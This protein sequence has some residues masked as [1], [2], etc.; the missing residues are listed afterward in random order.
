M[1]F[2]LI[3]ERPLIID[4]TL[5]DGGYLNQWHFSEQA[6]MQAVTLTYQADADVIEVGYVDDAPGLPLASACP[7]AW[8][9]SL[10]NQFPDIRLAGMIRPSVNEPEAVLFSRQGLLDL[11]RIPV[12]LRWPER[13]FALG[14][15]CHDHG[16][17]V[18]FNLTGVTCFD[19]GE[20][21]AAAAAVP[22]FASV[23]YLA[24]SRGGLQPEDIRPLITCVREVWSGEIGYHAHDSLGL[25]RANTAEALAAGC[26]WLDGSLDGVGL[27][28]RNLQ[29]A[30]ALELAA[31][32]RFDLQPDNAALKTR[33]SD[34][35]LSALTEAER[36]LYVSCAER[37]LRMEWVES[38]I[39]T[40]GLARS[41]AMP[42]SLPRR[43]WFEI[44]ELEAFIAPEDW[45]Q[46]RW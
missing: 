25:A 31:R 7:P 46:I 3:S 24:D 39:S 17:A 34:L 37:N 21:Q 44:Q 14:K 2:T 23:V 16:F 28:G 43:N 19:L 42:D 10:K 29:L 13:G 38:L 12:D 5:R 6:L 9:Q 45:R 30:D 4:V 11:L 32:Q 18:S 1:S 22:D 41:Q 8:L 35:G 33:A 20:I 27:G 40:F 15:I 26:Q 36:P